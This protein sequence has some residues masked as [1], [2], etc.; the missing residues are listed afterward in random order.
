MNTPSPWH[1]LVVAEIH[2][3]REQLV[4]QYHNDLLVYSEAAMA[5]CRALGLN[6]VEDQHKV[7]EAGQSVPGIAHPAQ[8]NAGPCPLQSLDIAR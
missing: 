3:T 6:I 1:D 7:V 8:Q 2:A 4:E 5:H